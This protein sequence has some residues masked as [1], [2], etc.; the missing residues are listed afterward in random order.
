MQGIVKMYTFRPCLGNQA[1]SSKGS[2]PEKGQVTNSPTTVEIPP[3][4][5]EVRSADMHSRSGKEPRNGAGKNSEEALPPAH[6]P[7]ER[8][9]LTLPSPRLLSTGSMESK[10]SQHVS[11]PPPPLLSHA[12]SSPTASL[13]SGKESFSVSNQPAVVSLPPTSYSKLSPTVQSSPPLAQK[14]ECSTFPLTR[15][16]RVPSINIDTPRGVLSTSSH[17]SPVH[18]C[19]TD[20]F[21]LPLPPSSTVVGASASPSLTTSSG[22]S[23]KNPPPEP[24]VS[25][26]PS[27]PKTS[28][29]S[30]PSLHPLPF[31]SGGLICGVGGGSA[32][33]FPRYGSND[34]YPGGGID[35]VGSSLVG[36]Q[37][38]DAHLNSLRPNGLQEPPKQDSDLPG[39][40]TTG[41]FTGNTSLQALGELPAPHHLPTFL[42]DTDKTVGGRGGGAYPPAWPM[43]PSGKAEL[44]PGEPD[45]DLLPPL[46][47]A[48][49]GDPPGC[50]FG[51]GRGI[52]RGGRGGGSLF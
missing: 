1:F 37:N 11:S 41:Y 17:P 25:F 20:A 10:G 26:P 9:H 8:S 32:A 38:I 24:T 22:S 18:S 42:G 19:P 27:P 50:N 5:S 43:A 33:P 39:R 45:N 36:R 28:F 46:G 12:P 34:L 3:L 15:H 31:G 48:G 44:F 35:P 21:P 52:G 6:S 30:S 4:F 13:K 51:F 40:H 23:E 7:R 2:T 47:G 14:E 49:S 16:S 29:P